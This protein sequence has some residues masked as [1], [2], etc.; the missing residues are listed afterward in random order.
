[1][2]GAQ[3][4]QGGR[5]PSEALILPCAI[6]QRAPD[7]LASLTHGRATE[8]SAIRRRMAM[9]AVVRH[10]ASGE[11]RISPKNPQSVPLRGSKAGGGRSAARR[12]AMGCTCGSVRL[13][14]LFAT[15]PDWLAKCSGF[16]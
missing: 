11:W 5:L 10:D 13:W 6:I 15:W 1:M 7:P 14:R 9:I 2:D 4:N 12:F 3:V 16:R 8:R